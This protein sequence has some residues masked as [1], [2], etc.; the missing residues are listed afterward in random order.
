M[1]C[2]RD[3]AVPPELIAFHRREQMQRLKKFF[4]FA[5]AKTDLATPTPTDSRLGPHPTD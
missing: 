1:L 4:R 3:R 2:R 5:G